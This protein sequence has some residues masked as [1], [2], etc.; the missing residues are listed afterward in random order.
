MAVLDGQ[1]VAGRRYVLAQ[2]DLRRF[3]KHQAADAVC[4]YVPGAIVSGT[5]TSS[6][7]LGLQ[8]V[9]FGWSDRAV[10]QQRLGGGDVLGP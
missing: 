10:V 8:P 7:R 1:K 5:G 2:I 4:E 9:E 6:Q 3:G